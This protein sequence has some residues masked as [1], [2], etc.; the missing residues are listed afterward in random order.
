MIWIDFRGLI[1]AP[2]CIETTRMI[3]EWWFEKDLEGSDRD[4]MGVLTRHLAGATEE[5]HKTC[6]ISQRRDKDSKQAPLEHV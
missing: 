3:D 5:N 6:H 4:L 2:F 1:N